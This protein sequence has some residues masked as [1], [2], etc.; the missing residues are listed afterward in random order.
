MGGHRSKFIAA[1]T[2]CCNCGLEQASS[3]ILGFTTAA[4]GGYLASCPGSRQKSGTN[5][6][7]DDS[8]CRAL[9]L[10]ETEA[11]HTR[12]VPLA[13]LEKSETG[14]RT[15]WHA[16]SMIPLQ[17]I[18]AG[19]MNAGGRPAVRPYLWAALIGVKLLQSLYCASRA[20]R[21]EKNIPEIE[22]SMEKKKSPRMTQQT[23]YTA[24]N[25]IPY[26][27]EMSSLPYESR[28]NVRRI[29]L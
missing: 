14:G 28:N 7:W 6:V 18:F 1:P 21:P 29:C 27:N 15:V 25:L 11:K 23:L 26:T 17:R 12:R 10:I 5:S 8:D 4:V 9:L 20:R 24:G 22:N 3:K 2:R 19:K 13:R 16:I